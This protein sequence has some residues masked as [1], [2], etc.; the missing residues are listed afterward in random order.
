MACG[1]SLKSLRDIIRTYSQVHRRDKASQHSSITGPIGLNGSLLVYKL[2]GCRFELRCSLLNGRIC[3]CFEKGVPWDS[4][5]Y[6][7]WIHYEKRLWHNMDI[8][9][10]VQYR[11]VLTTNF[12]QLAILVKWLSGTLRNK[13]L[14][15][16]V[17]LQSLKRQILRHFWA[18]SSL[19][20]RKLYCVDSLW[21]AYV[22]L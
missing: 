11:F 22:T 1:F 15:V 7:M 19:T 10:N 14:W 18:R 17:R 12:N 4:G 16:P 21:T 5:N 8:Q 13:W 2:S 9:S 6:R 20:F 3:A